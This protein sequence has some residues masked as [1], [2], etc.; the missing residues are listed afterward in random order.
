MTVRQASAR[1]SRLLL[2]QPVGGEVGGGGLRP[3]ALRTQCLQLHSCQPPT[4]LR[5]AH[6]NNRSLLGPFAFRGEPPPTPLGW[7][8]TGVSNSTRNGTVRACGVCG[9]RLH[10]RSICTGRE[11]GGSPRAG[12]GNG[13][14]C[15]R[16]RCV[17]SVGMSPS[18]GCQRGAHHKIGFRMLDCL[19]ASFRMPK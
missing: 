2:T 3:V 14:V 9:V 15:A 4:S 5:P 17:D 12:G 18:A 8:A 11:V 10:C 1:S 13:R 7:R 19:E 16:T 6:L